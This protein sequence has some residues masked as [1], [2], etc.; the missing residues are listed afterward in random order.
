M[1][2]LT[3]FEPAFLK[4]GNGLG[5]H[6]QEELDGANGIIFLCPKCKNHS[7][8]VWFEGT[9][10]DISPGPARWTVVRGSGINNLTLTPS[11]LIPID[12]KG[13]FTILEGNVCLI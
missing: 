1:A 8:I 5:W 11:I 4:L 13:H 3:E 7:I 6:T 10:K 2:R 9:P 12:C